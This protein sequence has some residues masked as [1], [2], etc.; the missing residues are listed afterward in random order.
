[1]RQSSLFQEPLELIQHCRRWCSESL[2]GYRHWR[3][4][5]AFEST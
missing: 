4:P 5:T 3:R 1:L 2:A